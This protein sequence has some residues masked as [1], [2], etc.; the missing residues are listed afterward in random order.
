MTACLELG[1]IHSAGWA[2]SSKQSLCFCLIYFTSLL[3]EESPAWTYPPLPWHTTHLYQL[4]KVGV[5]NL[6]SSKMNLKSPPLRGSVSVRNSHTEPRWGKKTVHLGAITPFTICQKWIQPCNATFDGH[7]RV[8]SAGKGPRGL[9]MPL[10]T[11]PLRR[12]DCSTMSQVLIPP[13]RI[14]FCR[15]VGK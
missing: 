10:A 14:K 12:S 2:V 15:S 6:F 9:E 1:L 4:W 3:A 8:Q 5:P 11:L 13:V 7:S